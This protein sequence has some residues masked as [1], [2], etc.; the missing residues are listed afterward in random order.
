MRKSR[1]TEEQIIGILQEYAAGGN[2]SVLCRKHGKSNTTLYKWK[3]SYAGMT[4]SKLRQM[5]GLEVENGQLKRLLADAM[6]DISGLKGLLAHHTPRIGKS[7]FGTGSHIL[8]VELFK[9]HGAKAIPKT[10]C[11]PMVPILADAP[12]TGL[13]SRDTASLFDVSDGPAF[14]ARKHTLSLSL[15]TVKHGKAARQG[16][17][18]ARGQCQCFRHP[19]VNTDLRRQGCGRRIMLNREVE[20]DMPTARSEIDRDV[21]Q[22]ASQRPCVAVS[23]PVDLGQ[24]DLGPLG[25]QR[26][27]LDFTALK[28]ERIV[29]ATPSESEVFYDTIEEVGVGSVKVAQGLLLRSNM[30][31]ANLVVFFAQH[32]QFTGLGRVVDGVPCT[33]LE[34]PPVIAAL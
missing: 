28:A 11:N 18:L 19:A 29:D 24:T 25:I 20:A 4:V 32:G 9:H 14:S 27:S 8:D 22:C 13:Y 10:P 31:S 5:K 1:F 15:S 34:L 16:Q 21:V 17:H 23:H 7:A 26:A 12:L 6:L 30:D 2:V 3:V 33:G